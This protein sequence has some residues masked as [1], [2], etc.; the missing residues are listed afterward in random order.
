MWKA[1]RR[2]LHL[3]F[4]VETYD[5]ASA[6]RQVQGQKRLH[7][8]RSMLEKVE[9]EVE[10]VVEI[11]RRIDWDHWGTF[12]PQARRGCPTRN[13]V[14][15]QVTWKRLESRVARIWASAPTPKQQLT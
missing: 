4:R 14:Q 7:A 13:S 2:L 8:L 3:S 6:C 1:D 15:V 9:M 12:Q 5:A 10:T 11:D